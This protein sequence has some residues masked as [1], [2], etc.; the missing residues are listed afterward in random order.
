MEKY[1]GKKSE[2]MKKLE[3]HEDEDGEGGWT[4]EGVDS[5]NVWRATYNDSIDIEV[6]PV[7][8]INKNSKGW[9]YRIIKEDPYGYGVEYDSIIESNNRDDHA[10]NP[11][12]A[13]RRAEATLEE[14]LE[15]RRSKRDEK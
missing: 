14:I 3:W 15:K 5:A 9:E 1:D 12:V 7:S 11:E 4:I 2:G 13:M 10:P 6:Y 8:L